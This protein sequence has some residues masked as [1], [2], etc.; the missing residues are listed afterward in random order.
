[1]WDISLILGG[2]FPLRK[3]GCALVDAVGAEVVAAGG[4]SAAL[5]HI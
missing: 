2:M 1:M 3:D 4:H 5:A